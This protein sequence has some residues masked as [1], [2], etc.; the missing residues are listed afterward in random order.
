MFRKDE[1]ASLKLQKD[2]LVL[3]SEANRLLIMSDCQRLRSPENWLR[4]MQT[5]AQAHPWGAAAL[6]A[7]AGLVA[8]RT[9]RRP[10]SVWRGVGNLSKLAVKAYSLWRL[11]RRNKA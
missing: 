5:Q 11:F 2:L 8:V 3:Q 1:L 10:G 4:G 7:I 6:A 9:A